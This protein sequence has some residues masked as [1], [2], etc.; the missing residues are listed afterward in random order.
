MGNLGAVALNR[1]ISEAT[2]LADLER[3]IHRLR[4]VVEEREAA[5]GDDAETS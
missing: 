3:R 1:Q 2:G 4:T 5:A